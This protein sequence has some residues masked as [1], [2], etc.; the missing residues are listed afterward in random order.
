MAYTVSEIGA[1]AGVSKRT[2]H[3]YDDIGLLKPASVGANGYRYYDEENLYTLQQILFY[4][5]LGM[6]LDD[7]R[8]VLH[9]PAFDRLAALR[10]HR[11]ALLDRQRRLDSLID[12]VDKTIAHLTE[13]VTMR[14]EELFGGFTPEEEAHYAQEAERLYD[15]DLVRSSTKRWNRYT[16][17]EKERIKAEGNAI[18]ADLAALIRCDPAHPDVQAVVARWHQHIR[19][20]YEPTPAILRGLGDLYVHSPDFSETFAA[21]HPDLPAFARDAVRVYCAGL[22]T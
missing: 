20:F 1:L 2:L 12:T 4:R 16:A 3:Y 22:D 11:Q 15:P 21:L 5:E 7:I 8:A 10:D 13:E 18:Y 6:K 9:S 17:A 14:K 19:Y